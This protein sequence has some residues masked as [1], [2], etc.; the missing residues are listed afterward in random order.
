MFLGKTET[1]R[2]KTETYMSE[3]ESKLIAAAAETFARY[4]VR[5][6]TMGDIAATAGLSRQTLYA[7]FSNKDE[8]LAAAIETLG[9]QALVEMQQIWAQASSARQILETYC[10]TLIL[11]QYDM[12]QAMPDS[13][14]LMSNLTGPGGQALRCVQNSYAQA[15]SV[16]LQH[17]RPDASTGADDKML[18]IAQFFASSAKGLKTIADTREV[19]S[20]QLALL[21]TATL[22]LLPEQA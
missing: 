22:A 17:L 3:N 8:I 2:G 16:A 14:E 1:K 7:R 11:K 13:D 5:R 19:L 15:L 18:P 12:V 4:G 6:T 10:E 9:Q 20:D 21:V